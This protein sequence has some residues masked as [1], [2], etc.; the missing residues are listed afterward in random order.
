MPF[1]GRETMLAWVQD[2]T[3]ADWWAAI[4]GLATIAVAIIAGYQIRQLRKDQGGWETLRACEKYD[5]DP[6]LDKALMC[7][8]EGE[9]LTALKRSRK[10]TAS[11]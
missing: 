2:R 3:W 9:I 11:S 1:E 6:V 4:Q 8:R 7:I 5:T 10:N